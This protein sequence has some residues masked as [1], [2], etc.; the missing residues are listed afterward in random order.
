MKVL[1]KD[2]LQQDRR[3][4]VGAL[5]DLEAGF[6]GGVPEDDPDIV[7]DLLIQ[8]IAEIDRKLGEIANQAYSSIVSR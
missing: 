3:K 4:L 5:N 1:G 2:R 6:I 8:R 7:R